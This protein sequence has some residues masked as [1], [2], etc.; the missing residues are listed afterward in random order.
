MP[1]KQAPMNFFFV[2]GKP[3]VR[4]TI[5][6]TEHN[7]FLDTGSP[8]HVVSKSVIEAGAATFN[9][10]ANYG[11]FTYKIYDLEYDRVLN[12]EGVSLET[13]DYG[14]TVSKDYNIDIL[15]GSF[16]GGE[17]HYDLRNRIVTLRE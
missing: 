13:A 9:R 14:F 2:E 7:A 16:L 5:S 12:L 3:A 1:A 17:L 8:R 10:E 6:G 15:L 4:L 11:N